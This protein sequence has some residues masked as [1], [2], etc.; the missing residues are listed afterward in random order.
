METSRDSIES[1]FESVEAY[2]KTTIE[3]SKLRALETASAVITALVSRMIV[4]IVMTL[5]VIFLSIGLSLLLGTVLEKPY[6]GFFIVAAFYLIVGTIMSFSL[7]RWM[8]E[9][10]SDLLV[11]QFHR[12]KMDK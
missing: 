1:L 3:L 11:S 6:Y 8:K 4:F 12:R 9:P 2:G 10:V 5:F 7:H